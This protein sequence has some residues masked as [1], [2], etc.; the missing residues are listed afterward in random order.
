MTHIPD[1]SLN[2]IDEYTRK[3]LVSRVERRTSHV[4]VLEE[5]IWLFC[6]RGLPAFI[7]SDNGPEFTAQRIRGWLSRLSG[8]PL[9]IEKGSP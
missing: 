9:F 5:L 1:R 3:C 8:G 2:L 6:M 7:R 4:E